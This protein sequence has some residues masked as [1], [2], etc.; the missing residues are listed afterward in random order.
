MFYV[1]MLTTCFTSFPD[2]TKSELWNSRAANIK[3]KLFIK[4]ESFN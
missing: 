4:I 3:M 1:D 2:I